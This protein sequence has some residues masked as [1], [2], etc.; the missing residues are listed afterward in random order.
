MVS[1]VSVRDVGDVGGVTAESCGAIYF[2]FELGPH[3]PYGGVFVEISGSRFIEEIFSFS[4]IWDPMGVKIS[5]RYSYK[6]Q[7]KAFKL[8]LNFLPNAP[9]KI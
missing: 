4:L 5:K 6:S 2:V 3:D 9:H 7:P 1:V 8:F